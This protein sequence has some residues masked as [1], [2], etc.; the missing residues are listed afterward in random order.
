MVLLPNGKAGGWLAGMAY[1][2][3][4]TGLHVY[5][6]ASEWTSV[7][8]GMISNK[9]YQRPW[10]EAYRFPI[11]RQTDRK[12]TACTVQS[13]EPKLILANQLTTSWSDKRIYSPDFGQVIKANQLI[14]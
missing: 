9:I 1:A 4:W 3:R 12:W 6:R 2:A 13:W 8:V 5:K 10:L 7:V 11:E 14:I